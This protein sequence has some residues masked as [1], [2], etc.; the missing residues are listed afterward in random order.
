MEESARSPGWRG[1]GSKPGSRRKEVANKKSSTFTT[2]LWKTGGMLFVRDELLD[3]GWCLTQASLV[4][5]EVSP[6]L[7]SWILLVCLCNQE[8]FK[9]LDSAQA[10]IR[11]LQQLELEPPPQKIPNSLRLYWCH[12]LDRRGAH[13]WR[14]FGNHWSINNQYRK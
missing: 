9:H 7:G 4:I 5:N 8:S 11:Q 10:T 1:T 12:S 3:W 6:K 2:Q 14:C 13:S